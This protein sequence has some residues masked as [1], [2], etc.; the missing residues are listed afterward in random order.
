MKKVHILFLCVFCMMLLQYI[1]LFFF[2]GIP[3]IESTLKHQ[4]HY[5]TLSNEEFKQIQHHEIQLQ[6]TWYDIIEIQKT[7][8]TYKAKVY[9]DSFEHLI[10]KWF[11]QHHKNEQSN[12]LLQW[13]MLIG[14][15]TE[16]N[17]CSLKIYMKEIHRLSF[18]SYTYI[19]AIHSVPSLPPESV[20]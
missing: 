1:L 10:K 3:F 7:G 2:H 9:E 16:N 20:M 17:V 8:N 19:N 13:I 6:G 5:I 12:S 4:S 18:Y 15:T 14:Y 11:D